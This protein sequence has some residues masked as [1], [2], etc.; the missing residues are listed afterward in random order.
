MRSNSLKYLE[1]EKCR[2]ITEDGLKSLKTLVN[3]KTL[4]VKDL[5]YVKNVDEI[6]QALQ[7]SLDQCE[8]TIEK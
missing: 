4:I 3:L 8:I 7:S 6:K 2:N 5:P 1:L